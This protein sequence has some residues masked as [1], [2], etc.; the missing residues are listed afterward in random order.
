MSVVLALRT[1]QTTLV[2]TQPS[3]LCLWA[4][5][6]VPKSRGIQTCSWRTSKLQSLA[7]ILIKHMLNQLNKFFR[8][9]RDVQASVLEINSAGH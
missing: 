7:Q 9:S 4:L 1:N 6:H 3:S 8:I 5:F 2:F